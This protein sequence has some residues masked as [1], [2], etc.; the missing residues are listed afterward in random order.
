M[1]RQVPTGGEANASA[2]F[3]ALT[4]SSQSIEPGRRL[5]T[6]ATS[7]SGTEDLEFLRQLELMG[8]TFNLF[9]HRNVT[10][11][12]TTG[13]S[14]GAGGLNGSFP[15]LTYLAGLKANTTAF[16]QRLNSNSTDYYRERQFQVGLRMRF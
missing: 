5:V 16:G 9:N 13:Y 14:L 11:I 15:T 8:E 2:N 10:E 6:D 12:E 1:N 7:R 4:P 3:L